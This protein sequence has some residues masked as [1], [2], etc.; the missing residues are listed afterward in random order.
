M[1]YLKLLFFFFFFILLALFKWLWATYQA[2]VT[3]HLCNCFTFLMESSNPLTEV[4]TGS[5]TPDLAILTCTNSTVQPR[6]PLGTVF[7]EALYYAIFLTFITFSHFTFTARNPRVCETDLIAQTN[8]PL[9]L[10]PREHLRLL[11]TCCACKPQFFSNFSRL[12]FPDLASK[13]PNQ[14]DPAC[15][16]FI[17]SFLISLPS[18]LMITPPLHPENIYSW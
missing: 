1:A 3:S 12:K 8:Q 7:S 10:Q 5:K 14:M 13:H 15:P 18:S 6:G 4:Q 11:S 16:S 17:K 2:T 9:V